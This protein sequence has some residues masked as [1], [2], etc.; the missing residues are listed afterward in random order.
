MQGD[1]ATYQNLLLA[2]CEAGTYDL[3]KVVC[4]VLMKRAKLEEVNGKYM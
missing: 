3:A 2:F 4:D 1:N